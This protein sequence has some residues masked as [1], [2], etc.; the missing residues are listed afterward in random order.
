M[1]RH[2][3]GVGDSSRQCLL[4]Q[5]NSM[6]ESDGRIEIS[7]IEWTMM[8]VRS[9]SLLLGDSHSLATGFTRVQLLPRILLSRLARVEFAYELSSRRHP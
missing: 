2:G 6:P 1:S 3:S 7:R 8:I 9:S 5:C 4:L